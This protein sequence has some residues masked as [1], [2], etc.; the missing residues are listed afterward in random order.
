M[1]RERLKTQFYCGFILYLESHPFQAIRNVARRRPIIRHN[2]DMAAFS[3]K[4]RN[5]SLI[6]KFGCECPPDAMLPVPKNEKV[7]GKCSTGTS[8]SI[9]ESIF[10]TAIGH[11]HRRPISSG[12]AWTQTEQPRKTTAWRHSF[13]LSLFANHAF[14]YETGKMRIGVV[15]SFQWHLRHVCASRS[16]VSPRFSL[17]GY[18]SKLQQSR[19]RLCHVNC[20][21]TCQR[22]MILEAHLL[23]EFLV[24]Y[25]S[26]KMIMNKLSWTLPGENFPSIKRVVDFFIMG[27]S[28]GGKCSPCDRKVD[29]LINLR[30]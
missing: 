30:T 22:N 7:N 6:Q 9:Q 10:L 24:K 29:K 13:C 15:S 3:Q 26:R 5:S 14:I 4:E 21:W 20:T 1:W 19:G 2:E 17:V 18:V 25:I 16:S 12:I 8:E 28:R 27:N 23:W 11:E